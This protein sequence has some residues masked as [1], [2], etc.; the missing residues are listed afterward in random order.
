MTFLL[1][2]TL[3]FLYIQGGQ[4]YLRTGNPTSQEAECLLKNLEGGAGSLT[5]SSGMAA[6][7]T[8]IST[9]VQN[10]DHVVRYLFIKFLTS[11]NHTNQCVIEKWLKRL[12]VKLSQLNMN[13]TCGLFAEIDYN[14]IFNY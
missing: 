12:T 2:K 10:G 13:S 1:C 9:V 8:A 4:V 6:I 5:F 7:T 14:L 11:E 3:L